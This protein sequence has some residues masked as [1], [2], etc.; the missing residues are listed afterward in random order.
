MLR[1]LKKLRRMSRHEVQTRIR[2]K[3][4][5][6]HERRLTTQNY[7]ISESSASDGLLTRCADM[8]PGTR[9][10]MIAG[11]KS[12]FPDL[13]R[14][15][16][17]QTRQRCEEFHSGRWNLFSRP[18]DLSAEIDWN[19]DPEGSYAWPLDFYA[20]LPLYQLP[21]GVDVKYV[22]EL[23]RHQFLAELGR[24]W[25][26]NRNEQSASRAI[27]L[28]G[29]W[30]EQSPIYRG[31]HWTSA[32]EV[33]MR[34]ISWGWM[35]AFLHEYPG[36][37]ERD[38][39]R[40]GCSLEEHGE[41][42]EHHLSYYSSPYN[43]LIGEAAGLWLIAQLCPT[44]GQSSRW[45]TLAADVLCDYG[46]RQFH[47]DG[48]SVEQASSYLAYSLSFIATVRSVSIQLGTPELDPLGDCALR[49]C[50]FAESLAMPNGQ[51]PMLGDG[52]SA[53][54]FPILPDEYWD[55]RSA[56]EW[57]RQS[58]RADHQPSIASE[59]AYWSLGKS[60]LPEPSDDRGSENVPAENR[61][62]S[63]SGYVTRRSGMDYLLFDVGPIAHG[64]FSDA[65]PS[66]AHGHS[67]QLQLI[68]FNRDGQLTYDSGMPFYGGDPTWVNYSRS[69]AAH[70][71]IE[72][73]GSGPVVQRGRLEWSN[74]APLPGVVCFSVHGIDF[75]IANAKWPGVS[76]Q[77]SIAVQSSGAVWV[78]DAVQ[79]NNAVECNVH[80]QTHSDRA[81]IKA[82][83]ESGR[84]APNDIAA[85]ESGPEGWRFPGYGERAPGIRRTF[86]G[87][88]NRSHLLVSGLGCEQLGL[89]LTA[90]SQVIRCNDDSGSSDDIGD[91]DFRWVFD[92]GDSES[93][94]IQYRM[95]AE[96]S[97]STMKDANP[98][99]EAIYW[100]DSGCTQP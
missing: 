9:S 94:V 95:P 46:P 19:Q 58:F 62:Y 97:V 53:R 78:A 56:F 28:L 17:N 13:H 87:G 74:H 75:L 10:E 2:E 83:G 14:Q 47:L 85:C 34:A 81:D 57:I 55:F 89:Q 16:S 99:L 84:L 92:L 96:L 67:D 63:D 54:V 68:V 29:D 32:L 82:W 42:L 69:S 26:L 90:G 41:F 8:L 61:V 70:N 1:K 15:W 93:T 37:Q 43:H 73:V 40:I 21:E 88:S 35:L 30:I 3:F 98:T 12:R 77:R 6:R 76:V 66:T 25:L 45:R 80:W 100:Q 5:V 39:Q 7:R 33:G 24:D 31:I 86:A 4:R 38:L 79:S 60:A 50:D 72:V 36:W 20:D 71:T 22:W 11:L 52:D 64:L 18:C 65:T 27:T 49:A 51:F 44:L 91:N 48:F 23:G 59:E